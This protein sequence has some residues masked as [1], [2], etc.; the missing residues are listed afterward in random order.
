MLNTV[1]ESSQIQNPDIKSEFNDTILLLTGV[2]VKFDKLMF[3]GLLCLL[4]W[5]MQSINTF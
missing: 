5:M 2:C 3:V 4:D 1:M